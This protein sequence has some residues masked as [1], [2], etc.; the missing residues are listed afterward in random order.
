MHTIRI[1]QRLNRPL[2]F[3]VFPVPQA[4]RATEPA[5]HSDGGSQARPNKNHRRS[6]LV[7]NDELRDVLA[8]HAVDRSRRTRAQRIGIAARMLGG[9]RNGP[10]GPAHNGALVIKGIGIAKIYDEAGVL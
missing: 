9:N 10:I 5:S 7:G 6:L 8:A 1:K 2:F 4:D 3:R